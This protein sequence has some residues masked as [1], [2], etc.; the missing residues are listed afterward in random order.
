MLKKVDHDALNRIGNHADL[1]AYK[2][3]V[4]LP[5]EE[6]ITELSVVAFEGLVTKSTELKVGNGVLMASRLPR[7]D[8]S[9]VHRLHFYIDD[10]DSTFKAKQ[11]YWNSNLLNENAQAEAEQFILAKHELT[12]AFSS[13]F[14][15]ENL[16]HIH[17]EVTETSRLA[18]RIVGTVGKGP[19]CCQTL[20]AQCHH[21]CKYLTCEYCCSLLPQCCAEYSA[22]WEM[23]VRS[24]GRAEKLAML[25]MEP[26]ESRKEDLTVKM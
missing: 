6:L 9:F 21:Y 7:D 1:D 10:K 12:G 14:V 3:N 18:E 25:L 24:Q 11:R 23:D 20:C 17:S 16:V 2:R 4:L 19:T 13:A 26:Y 8:G 5:N 22:V 15:E